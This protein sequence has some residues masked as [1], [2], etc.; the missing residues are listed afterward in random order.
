LPEL[1]PEDLAMLFAMVF[2]Q[3]LISAQLVPFLLHAR[4]VE[5]LLCFFAA[6]HGATILA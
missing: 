3:I 5:I 1:A 2:G 6:L 4:Q